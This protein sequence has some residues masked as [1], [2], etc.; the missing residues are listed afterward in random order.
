MSLASLPSEIAS[1]GGVSGADCNKGSWK[2]KGN[3]QPLA[4]RSTRPALVFKAERRR[5]GR[6][7]NEIPRHPA[8]ARRSAAPLKGREGKH[9]KRWKRHIA[10]TSPQRRERGWRQPQQLTLQE[11]R[12]LVDR[13]QVNPSEAPEPVG[14]GHM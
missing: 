9:K 13:P 4:E 3:S 8:V 10:N 6:Y 7:Q 5:L 1:A 2:R 11:A 14:G 12:H